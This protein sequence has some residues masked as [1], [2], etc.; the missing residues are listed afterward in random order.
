MTLFAVVVRLTPTAF[1]ED[2]RTTP[3]ERVQVALATQVGIG[4]IE[5]VADNKLLA[6]FDFSVEVSEA[7]NGIRL[8]QPARHR[9]ATLMR[10][11]VRSALLGNLHVV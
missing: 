4:T 11:V 9:L 10:E 1:R 8:D 7:D 3:A 2:G 5:V 6:I